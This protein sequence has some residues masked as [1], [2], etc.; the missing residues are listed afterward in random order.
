MFLHF[1]DSL[2]KTVVSKKGQVVIPKQ[3]RDELSL[4]PGTVLRVQ[5]EGKRII[6]EPLQEPP[7]ELFIELGPKITEPLLHEA[8]ITSD[9]AWRLLKDLGVQIE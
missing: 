9:K 4:T 8:K 5:V 1:G 3:A 7:R 2:S 6:L